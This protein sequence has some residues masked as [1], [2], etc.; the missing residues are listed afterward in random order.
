MKSSPSLKVNILANYASQL[1]SAGIG[2]VILPLYI[3]YM[4]PSP[5][6]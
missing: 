2:I 1:Y 6:V 5:M 4:G 3:K